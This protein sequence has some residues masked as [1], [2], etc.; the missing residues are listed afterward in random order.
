MSIKIPEELLRPSNLLSPL[1]Q[2][3]LCSGWS[4]VT[5]NQW[6]SRAVCWCSKEAFS[7]NYHPATPS[8]P[9]SVVVWSPG[10]AYLPSDK[11]KRVSLC[12]PQYKLHKRYQWYII[13]ITT[14]QAHPSRVPS[15]S[16]ATEVSAVQAKLLQHCKCFKS[17]SR[18]QV[19][20]HAQ[21]HIQSPSSEC[22][23]YHGHHQ[24]T[25]SLLY[26]NCP[27]NNHSHSCQWRTTT[28]IMLYTPRRA[29][30]PLSRQEHFK[31]S[32]LVKT[33]TQDN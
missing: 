7:Y 9:S 27:H 16:S 31:M 29:E 14:Y 30:E 18:I 10:Q 4:D 20:V 6:N 24:I 33:W 19:Y 11:I 3:K 12:S 15:C 8:T 23:V 17:K 21:V 2:T 22:H 13:V 26:Q 1:H 25:Q 32:T 28:S 5:S